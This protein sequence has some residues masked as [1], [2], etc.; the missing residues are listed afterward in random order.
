MRAPS[1]TRKRQA[2]KRPFRVPIRVLLVLESHVA[3]VHV[4]TT[5]IEARY[6]T[7]FAATEADA[8]LTLAKW[9]P[10]AVILDVDRKSVV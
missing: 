10:H 1:R 5:L 7:R 3:A 9:R 4:N 2:L 6:Q 8:A